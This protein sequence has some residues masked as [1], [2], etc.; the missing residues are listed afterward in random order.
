[1]IDI[2]LSYL[3][4]RTTEL[5]VLI[6]INEFDL[7]VGQTTFINFNYYNLQKRVDFDPMLTRIG[8]FCSPD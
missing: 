3:L 1:M 5:D 8:D 6:E 2:T 7:K 4:A